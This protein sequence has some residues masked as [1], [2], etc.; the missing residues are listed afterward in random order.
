MT[1]EIPHNYTL[2]IQNITWQDFDWENKDFEKLK[3][4]YLYDTY[5]PFV[6]PTIGNLDY[7]T[8]Q[9]N[10]NLGVIIIHNFRNI[11][12][13]NFVQTP[14]IVRAILPLKVTVQPGN[15]TKLIFGPRNLVSRNISSLADPTFECPLSRYLTG[16][17]FTSCIRTL[18]GGCDICN[19]N[20]LFMYWRVTKALNSETHIFLFKPSYFSEFPHVLTRLKETPPEMFKHPRYIFPNVPPPM[21][22]I[23]LEKSVPFE[24][25]YQDM[26]LTIRHIVFSFAYIAE[27][28]RKF[29]IFNYL[30]TVKMIGLSSRRRD[31]RVQVDIMSL[32]LIMPRRTAAYDNRGLRFRYPFG[33]SLLL[34]NNNLLLCPE[35]NY[36]WQIEFSELLGENVVSNMISFLIKCN[37]S[38]TINRGFQ[39]TLPSPASRVAYAHSNMW[40]SIVGNF[41]VVVKGGRELCTNR[42]GIVEQ[43]TVKDG[44]FEG[45]GMELIPFV[46]GLHYFPYCFKNELNIHRFVSCGKRGFSSLPFQELVDVFDTWIWLLILAS[47]FAV[48]VPF[49]LHSRRYGILDSIYPVRLFFEQGDA[50]PGSAM[51]KD[52]IRWGIGLFLLMGIVI[53]NAY[54]NTNVYNMIIP[55]SPVPYEF[56]K[57]LLQDNFTV[58]HKVEWLGYRTRSLGRVMISYFRKIKLNFVVAT[59][60]GNVRVMGFSHIAIATWAQ[61][62]A[63]LK[64]YCDCFTMDNILGH[65]I[66]SSFAILN[67]TAIYHSSIPQLLNA[68]QSRIHETRKFPNSSQII[69]LEMDHTMAVESSNLLLEFQKCSSVAIVLPEHECFNI[70]NKMKA[71]KKERHVFV[72]KEV[73]FPNVEWMFELNFGAL[74]PYM[75]RRIKAVHEHGLWGRWINLE[76]R[77][78]YHPESG[79]SAAVAATMAGNVVIVFVLYLCGIGVALCCLLIE[80]MC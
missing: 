23:F 58:Y 14:K 32:Q 63:L 18:W 35:V 44:P 49:R 61:I 70:M 73:L 17:N 75:P 36:R 24:S 26:V 59:G 56:Y 37:P 1:T 27:N 68:L 40:L 22:R 45:F 21:F 33:Q 39:G 79:D 55:R 3:E 16:F 43:A 19:R 77:T 8:S 47:I 72:G 67:R 5:F 9:I 4:E 34:K 13:G 41:S 76:K 53:S 25:R 50:I 15:K 69:Q 54:R 12:L 7:L 65:A 71:N 31:T 51:G 30:F 28:L 11:D 42:R 48:L 80:L 74:P 52:S 62:N 6:N 10:Q 60:P 66:I 46:R 2:Q 64:L 38:P 29:T 78:E 57:D 20:N